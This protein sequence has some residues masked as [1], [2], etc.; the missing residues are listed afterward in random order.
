MTPGS[1][2][3]FIFA[4]IRAGRPSEAMC[5]SFRIAS[6]IRLCSVNGDC[7]RCF[8]RF[9]RP[10]PVSCLNT[11]FTSLQTSSLAVSRPQSV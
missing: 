5:A 10:S 6:I 7:H 3:A 4:T 9:A 1:S 2:S 11:S 8:R